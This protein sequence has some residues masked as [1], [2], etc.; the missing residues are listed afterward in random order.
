[1]NTL[2][3]AA[4]RVVLS[5]VVFVAGLFSLRAQSNARENSLRIMFPFDKDV[6]LAD[7]M[8]NAGTMGKIDSL[9]AAGLLGDEYGVE[10]VAYSSPEGNYYYNLDLSTRRARSFRRWL[11]SRHPQFSGKVVISPDAEYWSELRSAVVSDGRLTDASKKSILSVIDSSLDPDDKEAKLNTIPGFSLV[12]RSFFRNYRFVEIRFRNLKPVDGSA[13][14]GSQGGSQGGTQAGTQ[15]DAQDAAQAFVVSDLGKILFADGSTDIDPDYMSNGKALAAI[16]A[17]LAAYPASGIK[18]LVIRSG[19][20]I[21]GDASQGSEFASSRGRSLNDYIVSKY[22]ELAGKI[23]FESAGED[24]EDFRSCV[25]SSRDISE[26]T[27][28][29]V[30]GIVGSDLS[31][32]EK[33]SRLEALPEYEEIREKVYPYQRYASLKADIDKSKAVSG[34]TA[35][36]SGRTKERTKVSDTGKILFPK[37]SSGIDRDYLSNNEAVAALDSMLASRPASEVKRL[38]IRSGGSIDGTSAANDRVSRER[39]RSL[40]DYITS[41]YPEL[42]DKIEFESVGEDWDDLRSSVVSSREISEDTRSRALEIIDSGLSD[43]TKEQRLKQMPEYEDLYERVFPRQR[44]ARA[45]IE[46]EEAPEAPVVPVETEVESA[47][48][49]STTD[50]LEIVDY[51]PVVDSIVQVNDTIALKDSVVAPALLPI[52]PVVRPIMAVST[53][54]LFDLA[55]T[56]NFAVEFPIGHK[57]SVYGEYTFPW[58]VTRAND[59]AWQILK[60]DLGVRSW[61]SK[62][63]KKKP[64]DIMTGHFVGIDLSAGYYDIEPRHTGWQGEFLAAGVE[65]GYAWDLGRNWRLDAYVGAGWMGTKYRYYEG[66]SRDEHLIYQHNG[67]MN[68]LGPTKLGV[69]FKYIFTT[70][71]KR[72]NGR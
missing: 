65:Y 24:W 14:G 38:V 34:K 30:L 5:L 36:D 17:L 33:K 7:Y 2:S 9:V 26:E 51:V 19:D 49:V 45:R 71:E 72:R 11:V 15:A 69:S 59:Q 56:P 31:D 32:G 25:A 4:L 42:S 62:H 16:E 55:I 12:R 35:V 53:N 58:W 21:D 63:D 47:D 3:R 57:W 61:L 46:Y 67:I 10:V 52:P 68:W 22:P 20:S 64:M 66:D 1:M 8:G 39:G 13:Q 37:A 18:R 44:Y 29:K 6:V 43:E 28:S 70:T 50:T 41:K 27:R 54:A 40:K 60:W 23:E 48:S